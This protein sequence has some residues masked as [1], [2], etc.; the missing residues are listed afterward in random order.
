M[1]GSLIDPWKYR[2]FCHQV[3]FALFYYFPELSNPI[4]VAP[5]TY[6]TSRKNGLVTVYDVSRSD[7][8]KLLHVNV[9][10]YALPLLSG[11]DE[12]HSG[13]TSFRHPLDKNNT[14]V[15]WFQLSNRGGIHRLD[16][17]VALKNSNG[18][19]FPGLGFEWSTDV[20]EMDLQATSVRPYSGPLEARRPSPVD[21]SPFYNCKNHCLYF[22]VQIEDSL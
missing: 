15:S 14:C 12:W 18:S 3:G 9:S 17:D 19:H 2:R 10:P 4:T 11:H 21:L 1:V 16:L 7:D 6:L 13:I 5:L 22:R 20:K 8:D